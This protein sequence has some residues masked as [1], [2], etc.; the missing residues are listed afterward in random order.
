[1]K[2]YSNH[3]VEFTSTKCL[4]AP[5]GECGFLSAVLCARSVFGEHALLNVGIGE[6][7]DRLFQDKEQN[8][9]GIALSLGEKLTLDQKEIDLQCYTLYLCRHFIIN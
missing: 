5:Y 3:V 8:S 2:E 6:H 4:T 9:R 7:D 1:M